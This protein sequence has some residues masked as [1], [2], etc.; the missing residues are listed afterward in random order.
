MKADDL[1]IE[2]EMRVDMSANALEHGVSASV[3]IQVNKPMKSLLSNIDVTLRDGG[4]RN[5]FNFSD[6]YAALHVQAM[7]KV[8][9]EWVEIGY[10]NGSFRPIDNIG[11]T[12]MS[13]DRYLKA[14]RGAAKRPC[15]CV[16]AHPKNITAEDLK[17]MRPL[18]DMVRFCID[19]QRMPLTIDYVRLAKSLGYTVCANLTR[20]SQHKVKALVELAEKAVDA[21]IDVIYLADSNGS[22]T[23]RRVGRLVTVIHDLVGHC[24]QVGFHAHDNLG[25]AMSNSIA[26]VNAGANFIDSSLRGMGK[27]AGNLKL[28]LWL[29]YLRREKEI[30][31]YNLA[32][33]LDQVDLLEKTNVEAHPIQPLDDL[34]LGLRDL[35]VEQRECLHANTARVSEMLT[36]AVL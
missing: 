11:Q 31:H 32:P 33:L 20:I 25:L 7:D 18:V 9:I 35:S 15:L 26:A 23:P 1:A 28:E 13:P 16:M 24:C 4:Y 19:P 21:G 12:G 10:R 2:Y 3:E 27:G 5:Q 17:H 30:D 22:M 34:I 6:D 8:G 14:L 29:A 36:K